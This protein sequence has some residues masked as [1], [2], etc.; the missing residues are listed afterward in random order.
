MKW[1]WAIGEVALLIFAVYE[2]WSLRKYD[3]PKV[4]PAPRDESGQG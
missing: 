1:E 4:K 3:K 2:L